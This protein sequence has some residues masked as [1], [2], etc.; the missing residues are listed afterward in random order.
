MVDV[1]TSAAAPVARSGT[2]H[3]PAAGATIRPA[4]SL[5]A[6]VLDRQDGKVRRL[7]VRTSLLQRV[8]GQLADLLTGDSGSER[9]L[10]DLEAA[11]AFVV[12]VDA[13]R[14]WFRYPR[15]LADLLR[16]ELRRSES[17]VTITELHG[18]AAGWFAEHGSAVEAIR[19]AQAAQ[20][21]GLAARLLV[22]H[23]PGLH[24]RSLEAAERYLEL[25]ARRTASAP[26][27]RRGT[28]RALLGVVRLLVARQRENLPAVAEEA[29]QLHVAAADPDTAQRGL[30]ADLRA[31]ALVNLGITEVWAGRFGPGQWHLEQGIALARRIGL[32]FLEFT[33]LAHQAPLE[34]FWSVARAAERSMQAIELARGHGWTNDPAASIAYLARADALV[35]QGRLDEAE[36]WV[37]QAERTVRL[38]AEPAAGLAL[39]Y[40]RGRLALVRGHDQEALAA[41]EGAERL[42]AFLAVPHLL[43]PRA[44]A[45]LLHVLVRIG[46]TERADRAL[47]GLRDQERERGEIRTATAALR[48]AQG[49][50]D[51]AAAVLVPVLDGSAP[52]SLPTWLVRA[53]LLKAMTCDALGDPAAAGRALERALDL[54]EPDRALS[55]F[56]LQPAAGLLQRHARNCAKH[57]DLIAEIVR[58]LPGGDA[59]PG[60]RRQTAPPQARRAP[61]EAAP[62]A[63][64]QISR[65]ESRVLRYL[66]TNLSAPEI[67]GELS[68]SVNTVR[69]HMRHLFVKLGVHSRTEAVV[70]ARSLGL[71]ASLHPA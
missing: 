40:V 15:L 12:A 63:T 66:P 62:R 27:G 48:L 5:L 38:E 56:V 10:Q 24:R 16:L 2:A 1:G 49:S 45:E 32:P 65:G 11:G 68:V 34:S 19:H 53:L 58:L 69:T 47:A 9:V 13:R 17:A 35:W 6:E 54:A 52:V 8:N 14:S 3:A 46:D 61:R 25:A 41:F 42:G 18:A 64:E 71:I 22:H 57:S 44:R 33:G 36:P 51:A 7:L 26:A 43:L 59:A 29:R 50:P 23:G 55:A 70:R 30:G 60:S 39:Y 67:A 21:W 37:R 31:L 20:D 28:L 4:A